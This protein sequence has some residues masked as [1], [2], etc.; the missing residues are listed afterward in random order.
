M[1]SVTVANLVEEARQAQR[2]LQCAI[3]GE[4][5]WIGEA[6]IKMCFGL[7][8]IGT[9]HGLVIEA[10][11][12]EPDHWVYR[13]YWWDEWKKKAPDELAM[14][15]PP[16]ITRILHNLMYATYKKGLELESK[17]NE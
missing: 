10:T 13:F 16:G 3:A 7:A 9:P 2:A 17:I 14:V 6:G 1:N 4:I 11:Q 8:K 12:L 5:V 15:K